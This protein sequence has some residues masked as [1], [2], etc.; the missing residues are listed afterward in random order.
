MNKPDAPDPLIAEIVG[1]SMFAALLVVLC[2]I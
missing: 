2:L 1:W